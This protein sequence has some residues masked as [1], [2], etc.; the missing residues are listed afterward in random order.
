[1]IEKQTLIEIPES[2]SRYAYKNK[3]MKLY[4]GG[5]SSRNEIFLQVNFG[6]NNNTKILA[7]DLNNNSFKTVMK[8]P[9][10][11]TDEEATLG[12]VWNQMKNLKKLLKSNKI[13]TPL[14]AYRTQTFSFSPTRIEKQIS[15]SYNSLELVITLFEIETKKI[16]CKRVITI[17][18]ILGDMLPE[19]I[20]AARA[21]QAT[22]EAPENPGLISSFN[23]VNID[24]LNRIEHP[25]HHRLRLKLK[26]VE[27]LHTL[28]RVVGRIVMGPMTAFFSIE[29]HLWRL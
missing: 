16:H 3:G 20:E 1:M 17:F 6:I 2:I 18:D 14:S 10:S 13:N 25:Y 29:K 7:L 5:K 11:P 8:A 28:N 26:D 21:D 24:Y 15:I 12:K 19:F 23:S 22:N 4:S 9:S 27:Y